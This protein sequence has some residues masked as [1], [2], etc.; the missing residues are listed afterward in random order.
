MDDAPCAD[1]TLASPCLPSLAGPTVENDEE[2]NA[3]AVVEQRWQAMAAS[4]DS[5]SWPAVSPQPGG[6]ANDSSNANASVAASYDDPKNQIAGTKSASTRKLLF[7]PMTFQ[8][9]RCSG[10]HC[11]AGEDPSPKANLLTSSGMHNSC[12]W[13]NCSERP[14]PAQPRQSKGPIFAHQSHHRPFIALIPNC[15]PWWKHSEQETAL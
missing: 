9:K 6:P 10:N 2:I 14:S 13:D 8:Q 7:L 3:D 11:P 15:S 5:S 12:P 4:S 1:A